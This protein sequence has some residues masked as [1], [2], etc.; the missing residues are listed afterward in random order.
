MFM[1]VY[2]EFITL[3]SAE[4]SYA[5]L[6]TDL[7]DPHMAPGVFHCTTGKDRTGWAAAWVACISITST[8]SS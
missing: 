6:F 3:P 8:G 5:T 1:Q 2:R 4:A 7:A